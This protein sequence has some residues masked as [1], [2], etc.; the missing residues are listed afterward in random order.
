MYFKDRK[1]NYDKLPFTEIQGHDREAF[2]GYADIVAEIRAR[3]SELKKNKT[4][5]VIDYYHG[6]RQ[7]EI[8][9]GLIRPLLADQTFFSEDCKLPEE[10]LYPKLE[11]NITD[12]RV[13][14][15]LSVRRLV[16]FFD[17]EKLRACRKRIEDTDRG[18]IVVYGVGASLV[19]KGDLLIYGDLSRWEIQCR[20]RSG[21]LD[22]WGAG[23]FEEDFLRKYKR[24]YFIEWRAL[25]RHKLDLFPD[26]DLLI[27]TNRDNSPNMITGGALRDGIRQMASQPFRLVPYFDEGV[28]GGRWMEEVFALKPGK[29]NFAWCFDGVPEE[30]AVHLKFRDTTV[31]I[32]ALDIVLREPDRL[33]GPEVHSRFGTEFP[34]RFDFLDTMDG[35]NLSLQVHPLTEYIQQTFGMH[36]TQD[37]SYYILDA[38]EDACVY[39][40]VR[41][42]TTKEALITALKEAQESQTFDDARYI[43]KF[44]IKKHDHVLIPAGTIH[45]SGKNSVVLEISAT[46]SIFTMKL[47]DWGRVGLDGKPRP[48]N[49]EHGEKVIQFSRTTDWVEKNLL[50]REITLEEDAHKKVERTGLHEL[51]FIETRRYWFD[52]KI[53]MDCNNSVN[54]LNLVE[55]EEIAVT[56]PRGRFSPFTVHYA[57]TFIVPES[58]GEYEIAP[59]GKSAGKKVAVIQAYVRV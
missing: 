59:A 46:P 22:N 45:C 43:N 10:K 4:V 27:D 2:H 49:I 35:G 15:V 19:A 51:E 55:G 18:L 28:W 52:E 8:E 54:M 56:S 24:G 37:E 58:V 21:E 6:V 36:Y 44:P 48:I 33:L 47:W 32:P 12:D 57:E 34:I 41:E 20:Y 26:I 31:E 14:G 13:F 50:H 16:E 7:K 11:R 25:D 9:S 42:G 53:S 5:V 1:T 40:G 39:L 3:I 29:H 30:N 38:K 23:N 17:E